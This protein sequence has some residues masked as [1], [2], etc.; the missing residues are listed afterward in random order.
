MRAAFYKAIRPGI[1][2]VYSR[3]VRW[4]CRSPYSHCELIFADGLAASS[5]FS[6]GGVRLKAIEFD[7][8]RWDILDLPDGDEAAARA[9]F[10]GQIGKPYDL[11]GNLGFVFR[12]IAGQRRAW[13]CSEAVAAALG[14]PE[15]W[16]YDPPTLASAL[17][18]QPPSGG[19]SLPA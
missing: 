7:A 9:W 4:W 12:P 11:L 18:R 16:R 13:F 14:Y 5:S 15:P 10:A 17:K 19:F 6:D 3:L 1:A 8:Q 2:G